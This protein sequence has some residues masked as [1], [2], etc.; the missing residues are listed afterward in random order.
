MF[1]NEIHI[2][3][4]PNTSPKRAHKFMEKSLFVF[5]FLFLYILRKEGYKDGK[6][7]GVKIKG[8]NNVISGTNG[9]QHFIHFQNHSSCSQKTSRTKVLKIPNFTWLVQMKS[10]LF[11]EGKIIPQ[12]SLRYLFSQTNSGSKDQTYPKWNTGL[13][14]SVHSV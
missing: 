4:P 3:L 9:F 8:A 12:K 5:L 1:D 14:G 13:K 6:H 2:F 7:W 11:R 10:Y